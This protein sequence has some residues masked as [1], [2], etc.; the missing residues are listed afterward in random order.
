MKNFKNFFY[1]LSL[2]FLV[3]G[4]I[5]CEEDDLTEEN[6][7]TS[8]GS[9]TIQ[10]I[11]TVERVDEATRGA[12]KLFSGGYNKSVQNY[13]FGEPVTY[14]YESIDSIFRHDMIVTFDYYIVEVNNDKDTVESGEVTFRV[15]KEDHSEVVIPFFTYSDTEEGINVR[16]YNHKIANIKLDY[17]SK[18]P[19]LANGE[20]IDEDEIEEAKTSDE[21]YPLP[22]L[23][24]LKSKTP[25][26]FTMTENGIIVPE[27]KTVSSFGLYCSDGKFV[28]KVSSTANVEKFELEVSDLKEETQYLVRAYAVMD[29]STFY[30]DNYLIV[31][32]DAKEIVR[33]NVTVGSEIKAKTSSSFTIA[34]NIVDGGTPAPTGFGV[35]YALSND[36][37]QVVQKI[38]SDGSATGY[39]VSISSLDAN[40]EYFVWAYAVQDGNTI[41]SASSTSV[42]TSVEAPTVTVG[43][44]VSGITTGSFTIAGNIVDGGTPAPTGFGV[45]YALSNDS[46]QVVQKIAS[47]GSATGYEVSISS[48]DANTEYF[49]WAYAVQDGNTIYSPSSTSVTTSVEAPTVTVGTTV[50]GITTGSFTIAGN[51][52]SGGSPAPT[53]FGIAYATTDDSANSQKVS[54]T[55]NASGYEVSVSGLDANT[56][57]FVWAYAVQDGNTIYSASST[58]ATTSNEAPTVTIGTTV[59]SKTSSSFTIAG[60]IVSGGSPAPTEFGVAYATTDDSANSQKK[61]SSGS[62]SG[63]EVSVTGLD[64]ETTYY[65]WTYAVQDGNTIYSS[66]SKQVITEAQVA[67]TVTTGTLLT[68]TYS[69]ISVQSNTVS[70]EGITESGMVY[71]TSSFDPTSPGFDISSVTKQENL[72]SSHASYEM[73]IGSLTALTY[74]AAAYATNSVGTSYGTVTEFNTSALGFTGDFVDGSTESGGDETINLTF[75]SK[76]AWTASVVSDDG[77]VTISSNSGIAGESLQ[78]DIT[79]TGGMLGSAV[80][81]FKD[82]NMDVIGEFTIT[83]S[84]GGGPGDF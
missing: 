23:G 56:E 13:L 15:N 24:T 22:V 35:A 74:Y 29:D 67:P 61:S 36:S 43:T 7:D 33:P 3:V 8:C 31:E 45:A 64:P 72:T 70:G 81:T 32:T 82:G 59:S 51:I 6:L 20:S 52:V 46:T 9:V 26:S 16:D 79:I 78:L 83:A 84:F 62:A 14:N 28:V 25:S 21:H 39:E 80:V 19:E 42:T 49:V 34:G 57:Y 53:E 55:G 10:A 60:N 68:S 37:T 48:L 27:S 41:Y 69:S 58:S 77:N 44:T 66:S 54:S 12:L 5:S 63:Y 50:S 4:M 40:T 2:L 17:Q 30:S 38:A 75:K 47:D 1:L 11:S 65:V 76:V 18:C 71:S 73:G